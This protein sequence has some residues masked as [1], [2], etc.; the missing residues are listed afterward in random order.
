M[1]NPNESFNYSI[2][3][4]PL[5]EQIRLFMRLESMFAQMNMH[6][7]AQKYYALQLFLDALFD[8]LDFLHRYEIRSEILKELQRFKTLLQRN[9]D[10]ISAM[11]S[12]VAALV[13]ELEVS[14]EA[15]HTLN[16]NP[17]GSLRENELLNS[18][19][20]RNFNQTG[21]CLF[22]VPAYQFWLHKNTLEKDG[23]LDDCYQLFVPISESIS[24]ILNML[25]ESATLTNEFTNDGLFLKTLQ[26]EKR[27]QMIRIHL[28]EK[29][30]V[31]PR[32]SGDNH[33]FSIRFMEQNDPRIRSQQTTQAVNFKLQICAL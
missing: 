4:Q 6:Y 17:I 21:N 3:E 20:Q 32:V 31:F 33:R 7:N 23:F 29:D 24:L 2:Y 19:R 28:K 22:E 14:L 16:F 25:R 13:E 5:S 8:V 9:T 18:L 12:N 11:F 15:M 27:N 10:N 1:N 30:T 26:H